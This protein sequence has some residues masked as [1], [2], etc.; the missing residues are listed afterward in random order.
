LNKRN[1]VMITFRRK[2]M[3]QIEWATFLNVN[4]QNIYH[5]RKHGTIKNKFKQFWP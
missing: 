1:S 5:W 4:Y 2:T 3:T